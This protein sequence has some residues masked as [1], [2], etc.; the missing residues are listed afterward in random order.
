MNN[1]TSPRYWRHYHALPSE[2]QKVADK[3]FQLFKQNPQPPSLRFERNE[4]RHLA[5]RRRTGFRHSPTRVALRTGTGEKAISYQLIHTPATPQ[6][7][8]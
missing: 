6:L 8:P 5:R 7:N 4:R 1:L 2:I 3:N